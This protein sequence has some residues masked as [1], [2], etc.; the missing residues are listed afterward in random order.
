MI[1]TWF[2]DV[3]PLLEKQIYERYYLLLPAWRREKADRLRRPQDKARSAGA[4]AL[5]QQMRRFY[6]LSGEAPFNLS[7][8]GKYALCSVCTGRFVNGSGAPV[9]VGCDIE[10]LGEFHPEIPRRFFCPAEADDILTRENGTL[11]TAAFYRYWVLK[12]SF[13][14]ATGLGMKL[15]L[16]SFEIHI[17]ETGPELIRQPQGFPGKYYY[18]EYEPP[19]KDARIAVCSQVSSF[20]ELRQ[21]FY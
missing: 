19:E 6:Q 3:T 16:Q 4:W 1:Q 2:A 8:S 7:H 21:F 9:S 10:M 17:G 13:I 18:K 15:D 14:K 5:Y 20:G 12:E 11:Q